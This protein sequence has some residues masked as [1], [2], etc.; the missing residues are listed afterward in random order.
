MCVVAGAKLPDALLKDRGNLGGGGLVGGI[1]A[2]GRGDGCG[3]A[4][5]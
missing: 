3:D 5:L 1:A 4:G 2:D